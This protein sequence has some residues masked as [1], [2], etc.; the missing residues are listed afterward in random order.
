MSKKNKRPT[1]YGIYVFNPVMWNQFSKCDS[2]YFGTYD[3]ITELTVNDYILFY[4][5]HKVGS[6]IK[7]EGFCGY[8]IIKSESRKNT[9][10]IKIYNDTNNQQYVTYL[11]EKHCY[12]YIYSLNDI[13]FTYNID[14]QGYKSN[15]NFITQIRKNINKLFII[16]YEGKQLFNSFKESI[17]QEVEEEVE[18]EQ[19]EE[20]V[21]AS[22]DDE[23]EVAS[24]DDEEEEIVDVD[25]ENSLD[26]GDFYIQVNRGG[27]S[28]SDSEYDEDSEEEENEKNK[29]EEYKKSLIPVLMNPCA[30]F[31]FPE[32]NLG[33]YFTEHY[34][35]C[36][37]CVKCDN[38]NVQISY[39]MMKSI[40]FIRDLGDYED[41]DFKMAME[42][43]YDMKHWIVEL[44]DE[45]E[46]INT[47]GYLSL[48]HILIVDD[49]YLVCCKII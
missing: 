13:N 38:N 36:P 41:I 4:Y 45:E 32:K 6:K 16:K 24:D 20:I 40:I 21:V 18:E 3:S 5:I 11:Q 9:F 29:S 30:G 43:Y 19:E 12:N 44:E 10:N 37:N 15:A 1:E 48:I 31:K 14:R 47:D 23:E 26:R 46:D 17:D 35:R 39:Y 33:R 42:A 28:G 22:D 34:L 27:G 8:G 25:S 49:D 7:Q 2:N